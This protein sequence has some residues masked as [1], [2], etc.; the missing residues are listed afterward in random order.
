MSQ[1]LEM[2]SETYAEY[3]VE[4]YYHRIYDWMEETDQ[5]F[6]AEEIYGGE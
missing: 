1:R 4:E 3:G 2:D 6:R 5:N